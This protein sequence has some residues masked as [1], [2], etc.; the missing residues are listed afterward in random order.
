M[1]MRPSALRSKPARSQPRR[2]R[3]AGCRPP[4][5]ASARCA[6]C[7]PS[8]ARA[9]G[10]RDRPSVFSAISERA[11]ASRRR[12]I[13]NADGPRQRVDDLDRAKAPRA[14]VEALDPARRE[15][16][17]RQVA[18]EAP[19][20][21]GP[22]HLDG[23]AAG[24]PSRPK[25]RALWT[26]ATEAAATARRSREHRLEG[27]GR[28]SARS[29]SMTA[30]SRERAPYGPAESRGRAPRRRRLRRGASPGTAR[31]SPRTAPAA[32]GPPRGRDLPTL[33][34]ARRG[35]RGGREPAP[36]TGSSATST[37]PNAPSRA[38]VQPA[39]ARRKGSRN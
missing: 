27:S 20:D 32:T 23:D 28:P 34:G 37:R 26:C 7:G 3:T 9:R 2:R 24:R 19:H 18:P 22:Q 6:R 21:A 30:T 15:I 13:S 35:G 10:N 14:R 25:M 5:R 31:A 16:E 8:R 11:A 36:A 4:I 29:I 12:S 1:T 38:S 17:G 39:T 33:R